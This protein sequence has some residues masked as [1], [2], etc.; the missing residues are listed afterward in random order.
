MHRRRLSR[1]QHLIGGFSGCAT[2]EDRTV[3]ID[4]EKREH[5]ARRSKGWYDTRRYLEERLSTLSHAISRKEILGMARS[6]PDSAHDVSFSGARSDSHLPQPEF[7]Q[8]SGWMSSCWFLRSCELYVSQ[9]QEGPISFFDLIDDGDH[10]AGTYRCVVWK[11]NNGS[12][13]STL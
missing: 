12:P 2:Q 3:P 4:T 9:M 8:Q 1:H 5:I 13:L 11:S 7:V 10:L 6:D